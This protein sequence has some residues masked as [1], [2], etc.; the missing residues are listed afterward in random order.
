[1]KPWIWVVIISLSIVIPLA[2]MITLIVLLD[3]SWWW[4][5]FPIILQILIGIT[6]TIII[7]ILKIKKRP[8]EK[9]TLDFDDAE[10][11]A[12]HLL[13]Y[14]DDDPDNFIR[15]DRIIKNVG[16]P[17]KERTPILWLQGKVS[18]MMKRKDILINLKDKTV[19]PLYLSNKTNE[20]VENI[21]KDYAENPEKVEIK[22]TVSG[23]DEM[24][25]PIT[26]VKTKRISRAE[27]QEK[28]DTEK[29]E[30]ANRF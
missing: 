18:E 26:T 19:Y 23:R 20:E 24:G 28:E 7:V 3:L 12:I 21:I 5:L 6:T 2:I 15:E 8:K 29:A 13:K 4:I 30:E 22:E 14:D 16:E 11:R 25:M 17:G 1:M 9:L 27:K 10:K